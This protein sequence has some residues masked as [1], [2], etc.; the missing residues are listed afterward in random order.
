MK[1]SAAA[2]Q[3]AVVALK[4]LGQKA[5]T[6]SMQS[7]LK[8]SEAAFVRMAR[9]AERQ[10]SRGDTRAL[11][12]TLAA[13]RRNSLQQEKLAGYTGRAAQRMRETEGHLRAIASGTAEQDR[14]L[15]A[16]QRQQNRVLE[17]LGE[18]RR[19]KSRQ[20]R[21]ANRSAAAQEK[22]ARALERSARK[23][24]RDTGRNKGRERA[25]QIRELTDKLNAANSALNEQKAEVMR[26]NSGIVQ[27]A[28][29]AANGAAAARAGADAASS[30]CSALEKQV[31]NLWSAVKRLRR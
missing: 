18:E 1:E 21:A 14:G 4:P 13:M 31:G 15:T 27:L 19:Y 2:A 24:A 20:S 3:K 16:Q 25:G 6:S 12:R 10:A 28:A 26:L 29:A 5:R 11:D 22:E 8:R 17:A 7:A 9:T 23:A 30:R